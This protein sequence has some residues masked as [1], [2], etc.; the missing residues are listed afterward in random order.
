MRLFELY[1][2]FAE[3]M[4]SQLP[5]WFLCSLSDASIYQNYKSRGRSSDEADVRI[6][7]AMKESM[8]QRIED[9]KQSL[10]I[11]IL[12]GLAYALLLVSLLPLEHDRNEDRFG[13][14]PAGQWSS[15]SD[16]A[17]AH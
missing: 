14:T 5:S 2:P 11:R 7:P 10:N 3:A 4:D 6:S 9:S 12:R 1:A 17:S 8:L 16:V 13:P 15:T